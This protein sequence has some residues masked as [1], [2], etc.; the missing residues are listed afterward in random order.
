MTTVRWMGKI[1][2][3]I[4]KRCRS[5]KLIVSCLSSSFPSSSSTSAVRGSSSS[6]V[7]AVGG[8]P[9]ML[10]SGDAPVLWLLLAHLQF[11]TNMSSTI[12]EA[13]INFKPMYESQN[14][15][16]VV[17]EALAKSS[18]DGHSGRGMCSQ[19]SCFSWISIEN[20]WP[21]L[22][23]NW[24][25]DIEICCRIHVRCFNPTLPPFNICC[26]HH[27]RQ[28]QC[29]NH[30]KASQ[31]CQRGWGR[32][33][34]RCL[35]CIR[36]TASTAQYIVTSAHG[37]KSTNG[38]Q[39]LHKGAVRLQDNFVIKANAAKEKA[40]RQRPHAVIIHAVIISRVWVRVSV[41]PNL[42]ANSPAQAHIPTKLQA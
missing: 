9:S 5:W 40:Q 2:D 8:C 15:D 23:T 1:T 32:F 29:T 24:Q 13:S 18:F 3:N 11:K 41:P 34:A 7:S 20:I 14:V 33:R 28:A 30:Q 19:W 4:R 26:Q 27:W 37:V 35:F 6:L 25:T 38:H 10:R 39:D 36:T 21:S 17:V 16:L 42:V 12:P 31:T 22:Q